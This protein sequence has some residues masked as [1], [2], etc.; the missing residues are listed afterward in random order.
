[1]SHFVKTNHSEFD[2]SLIQEVYG[3][4]QLALNIESN[5]IPNLKIP[6][7]YSVSRTQLCIERIYPSNAS[8]QQQR[9]FAQGLAMLHQIRQ[10][11]YGLAVSNYI[12]LAPQL[13]NISDNWGEF[14]LKQRLQFQVMRISNI[15][16]QQ[17]F[18]RDLDE[19]G[20]AL[21]EF[22]NAWCKYPSLL[23][24]D[25]WSGNVLFDNKGTWLIDPAIYYGD[26][27][28]DVAMTKMFGG[29]TQDFYR[30][31][32]EVNPLSKVFEKK[33]IIYNLY[34]YLNHFNLFGMSY[35]PHVEKGF[36]Y[37]RGFMNESAN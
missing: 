22:L 30:A 4:K 36:E 7:V 1:M 11:S 12:G 17:R 8:Q 34:H 32:D 28:V 6:R 3:L 18:I 24:G 9:Q 35:L 27:E 10:S 29:F 19:I 20:E 15:S 16:L 25:L 5:T 31:Y 2:D 21:V 33:T 23:H 14:F 37:L 13:N 26:A